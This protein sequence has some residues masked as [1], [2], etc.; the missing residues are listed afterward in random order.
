M[1]LPPSVDDAA[2]LNRGKRGFLWSALRAALALAIAFFIS[3]VKLDFLESY[4]YDVRMRL[5]PAPRTTDAVRLLMLNPESIERL[6]GTPDFRSHA[7]LL[8]RL[9]SVRPRAIV[10]DFRLEEIPGSPADRMEFAAVADRLPQLRLVTD[11]LEMK[12]EEGKLRLLPPFERIRVASGPKSSDSKNFA[13]DGVTRR[14]LIEY[15]GQRMVHLELAASF[16]PAVEDPEKIRGLF[17]FL[18]TS[19]AYI[20]FRPTGSLAA[21]SFADVL[22]GQADLEQFR[23][24]I[25]IIGQDT[26]VSER[27]YAQTPYSREAVAMTSAEVHG[28]IVETLIRNDSPIRGP[29]WL[30]FAFIALICLVTVGVL[31]TAKPTRGL[32]V[33]GA[34]LFVFLAIAGL[35]FWPG[36]VWVSMAHP[37]LA[38]FLCSYFFIPYRL[39][40]ENRRSWEIYQ[41]HRLLQQVEELKTNF[42]SMMSHDLKTPIARIQGMTDVIEKDPSPLSSP[43]REALDTIRSSG[44]DLLKFINS[45]LQYG[46]IEAKQIQLHRQSKDVNAVLREVIKKHEFLAKLKRIQ[47]LAEL[48][49]LFPISVDADLVRQVLSNLVENAIKYSPEETKILVSSEERDGW[50]VVQV[51]DQGPGIPADE[52]PN[53]FMKFF[54]SKNAKSSPVK[55]SGLG[56]YLAKYFTELHGGRVSVESTYGQGCTFTVEL[57]IDPGRNHAESAGG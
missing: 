17:D 49:P 4:F 1:A 6:R 31:F 22:Q 37:L 57:P 39:I 2:E 26:Q 33:I 21:I 8:A 44:D 45:I 34:T 41:K 38:F 50:V 18:G 48:E 15:Q 52:L 55:G 28:N 16:N 46:R 27:D 54:R 12:G 24:R 19:Q 20:N 47:I 11:E 13:K 42:I 7:D 53:I 23:D 29:R 40:V 9:E 36:G 51:A 25:V 30:D 14:F 35:L 56:L 10:Y 3:G 5:R 32:L 43:Q